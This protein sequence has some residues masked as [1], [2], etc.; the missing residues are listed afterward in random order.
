MTG[1]QESSVIY[2]FKG[3]W[4]EPLRNGKVRIFFRK[5]FP[6]V[7]PQRVYFYVGSP[8]SAVIGW[9]TVSDMKRIASNAALSMTA[10]GAINA[11]ELEEYLLNTD[12]VGVF[13]LSQQHLFK[14]PLTI[15]DLRSVFNFHPPQNFV[16]ISGDSASKLDE[17]AQ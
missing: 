9:A 8:T 3:K 2:S 14:N 15:S 5:R 10:D 6:R 17:M 13:M 16:Q 11:K 4:L 7:T 1:K 12:S